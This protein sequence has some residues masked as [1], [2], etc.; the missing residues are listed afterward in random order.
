MA[1]PSSVGKGF[2]MATVQHQ[3]GAVAEVDEDLV[4]TLLATGEWA[5][6]GADKAPVRRVRKAAAPKADEASDEE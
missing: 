4:D 5:V 6:V 2:F 3:A 1:L